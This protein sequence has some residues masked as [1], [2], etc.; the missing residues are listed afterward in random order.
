M[1]GGQ[2]RIL[3]FI[4]SEPICASHNLKGPDDTDPVALPKNFPPQ[5]AILRRGGDGINLAFRIVFIQVSQ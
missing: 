2:F 4:P 3:D 5:S 1:L